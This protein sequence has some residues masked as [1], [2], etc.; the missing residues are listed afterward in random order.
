MTD[1]RFLWWIHE[2]LSKIHGESEFL[3]YMHHLRAIIADMPS[4]AETPRIARMDTSPSLM[5]REFD[6]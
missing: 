6:E 2:R 5:R 1:K 3:D 4:D